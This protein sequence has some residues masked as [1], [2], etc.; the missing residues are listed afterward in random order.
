MTIT[1]LKVVLIRPMNQDYHSLGFIHNYGMIQHICGMIYIIILQHKRSSYK[2]FLEKTFK[3]RKKCVTI[4]YKIKD[5][6]HGKC[7]VTW[8]LKI[9]RLASIDGAI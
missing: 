4:M 7:Y 1:R 2:D 9:L 6:D 5:M 3:I 8:E